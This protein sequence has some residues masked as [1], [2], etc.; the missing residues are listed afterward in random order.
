L[1]YRFRGYEFA[2]RILQHGFACCWI[3]DKQY[4][5]GIR[6]ETANRCKVAKEQICSFTDIADSLEISGYVVYELGRGQR[7]DSLPFFGTG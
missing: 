1:D 2:D 7:F 3:A 6:Q 5:K 4:S